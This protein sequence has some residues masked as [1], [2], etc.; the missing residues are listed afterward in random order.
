MMQIGIISMNIKCIKLLLFFLLMMSVVPASNLNL[1]MASESEGA[2]EKWNLLNSDGE[3]E[4][5][6]AKADAILKKA[7]IIAESFGDKD[8]DLARNLHNLGF[9]NYK[10]GNYEE[11]GKY[12]ER[13]LR[14]KENV[15]GRNHGEVAWTLLA[16]G[17]LYRDTKQYSKGEDSLKEAIRIYTDL[18]GKFHPA[19]AG[20]MHDLGVLY[21]LKGDQ[22]NAKE[23]LSDALE[24]WEKTLG[25]GHGQ[26][27]NT[28]AA[29]NHYFKTG[30]SES[31]GDTEEIR[32]YKSEIKDDLSAIEALRNLKIAKAISMNNEFIAILVPKG[33]ITKKELLKAIS[34]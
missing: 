31:Q 1:L 20:C 26:Y 11:S 14:V 8:P 3:K 24:V 17:G 4:R 25:K 5:D 22:D 30:T 16:I 13:A 6:L 7:L 29:Y 15:Y 19:V 32:I 33:L 21:A 34:K 27:Q 2:K 18:R 9:I 12:F 10:L 28:L 23:Y